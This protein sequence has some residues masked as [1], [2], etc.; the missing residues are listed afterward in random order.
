MS[1]TS[2]IST[3]PVYNDANRKGTNRHQH[4]SFCN[5]YWFHITAT[6]L[7]FIIF[8]ILSILIYVLYKQAERDRERRRIQNE[9]KQK[10]GFANKVLDMITKDGIVAKWLKANKGQTVTIFKELMNDM[11]NTIFEE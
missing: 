6:L 3:V 8:I 4:S 2:I 10:H 7:S 9:F 5:R 1:D 11:V